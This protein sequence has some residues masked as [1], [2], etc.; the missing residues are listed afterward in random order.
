MGWP[1]A[2]SW[3]GR[4][5]NDLPTIL[6]AICVAINER[7]ALRGVSVTGWTVAGSYPV[8]ADFDGMPVSG[9]NSLHT[10]KNQILTVLLGATTFTTGSS[11]ALPYLKNFNW[12]REPWT[13]AEVLADVG[14]L[15]PVSGTYPA[16]EIPTDSDWL[17]TIKGVLD[18]FWRIQMPFSVDY[19]TDGTRSQ[20]WYQT[21]SPFFPQDDDPLEAAWA[22][23][24]HTSYDIGTPNAGA[25]L[26]GSR[27]VGGGDPSFAAALETCVC[28]PDFSGVPGSIQRAFVRAVFSKAAAAYDGNSYAATVNGVSV[29]T[30]AA[31]AETEAVVEVP[32][33]GS[34][35]EIELP[36]PASYFN[37]DAVAGYGKSGLVTLQ[38][39]SAGTPTA[40][41]LTD[42]SGELTDQT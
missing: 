40:G 35:Y 15:T 39:H 32:E 34:T 22:D 24:D 27:G 17:L 2:G 20:D 8:A 33:D 28:T 4:S 42:I 14:I 1:F 38:A 9:S 12:P 21:G 11:T 26:L 25:Y 19:S 13:P 10:L 23:R 31:G 37:F 41:A 18:R 7:E 36:G 30:P 29:T 6:A 16:W 5:R 3:E